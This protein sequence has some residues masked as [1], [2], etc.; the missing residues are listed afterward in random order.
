[1]VDGRLTEVARDHWLTA[2]GLSN[3]C[4]IHP[5]GE[6]ERATMAAQAKWD[7]KVKAAEQAARAAP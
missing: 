5:P 2:R 4:D 3:G 1:M 7:A 6:Q